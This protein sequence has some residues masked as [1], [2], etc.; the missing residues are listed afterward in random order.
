MINPVASTSVVIS[1][2]DKTAGPTP[3]RCASMGITEPTVVRPHAD[4]E[5]RQRH[6]QREFYWRLP[7]QRL[8]KRHGRN[9]QPNQHAC[10]R[11]AHHHADADKLSSSRS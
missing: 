9:Q 10:R 3:K 7:D 8:T 2:A 4:R 6:G 11:L 5:H 1:G